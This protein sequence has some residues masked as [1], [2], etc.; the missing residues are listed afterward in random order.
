[1]PGDTN[2]AYQGTSHMFSADDIRHNYAALTIQTN[3]EDTQ[4]A[5]NA[6]NAKNAELK[7]DG[8]RDVT[9]PNCN[10]CLP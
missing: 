5:I 10:D 6:I 7:K 9:G 2:Y 1:V 8:I 3:P 4:K